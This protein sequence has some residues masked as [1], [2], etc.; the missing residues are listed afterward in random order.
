MGYLEGILGILLATVVQ[1]PF[2]LL[3]AGP[4]L[5]GAWFLAL[6][7]RKFGQTPFRLAAIAAVA[8]AGIAPTYG[9]HGSM[10][11]AYF[12]VLAG[13]PTWSY[14]LISFLITW[15]LS[16]FIMLALARRR[17]RLREVASAA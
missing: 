16:S 11:P 2:H 7:T 9:A 1:L 14:F 4:F 10:I 13:D 17:A 5:A 3:I 8:S 15:A 12:A 6:L